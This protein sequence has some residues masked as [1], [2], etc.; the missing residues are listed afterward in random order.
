MELVYYKNLFLLQFILFSLTFSIL[1][2]HFFIN[3]EVLIKEIRCESLRQRLRT[4]EFTNF[5]VLGILN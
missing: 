2:T 1:Y 5:P 4:F 3:Y